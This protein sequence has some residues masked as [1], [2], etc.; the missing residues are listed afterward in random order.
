MTEFW[1]IRH[2]ESE[3]NAGLPSLADEST[4]L[5]PK[6]MGQ[7]EAVARWLE[8]PPDLFVVSPYLRAQ[9]TAS[10]ALI[11][12]PD[13]PAETWE[14]QEYTYLSHE[15]YRGT[16]TRDRRRLSEGYFRD[17]DPDRVIGPGGESF[18]QFLDRV[19][20]C[21]ERL[22]STHANRVI[23]FGHGWFI[24][25]GLWMLYTGQGSQRPHPALIGQIK[26][27]MS[28]HRLPFSMFRIFQNRSRLKKMHQ[29]LLFS[30]AIRTPNCSII[31]FKHTSKGLI[32]LTGYEADHLPK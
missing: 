28:V 21:I 31:K 26:Q 29:F 6:G 12:F 24:R 9:Q 4:P 13:I 5:T 30:G 32:D 1:F 15:L 25:A 11:K 19:D 8:S 27:K 7:A 23:L 22:K 2:G 16:T 10:P 14:I 20:D 18:N 3:T 17:A